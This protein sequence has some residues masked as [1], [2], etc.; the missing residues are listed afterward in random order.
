VYPDREHRRPHNLAAV[1]E[2]A[3]GVADLVEAALQDGETPLVI[4]G[5]CTIELDVLSGFLRRNVDIGLL[6]FDGGM[7]LHI[8]LDNP[9]GILDSMI[10][11][12][13]LGEPGSAEEFAR[14]GLRFPLMPAEKLA[15]FGYSRNEPEVEI[16]SRR[17]TPRYPVGRAREG[18]EKAAAE[19]VAYQEEVAGRFLGH[20]DVDVI[21]FVDMPVAAVPPAQRG[22]YVQRDTRLPRSVRLE[23]EMCGAPR[24]HRVQP[25]P[26]RQSRRDCHGLCLQR[27]S[28][29]LTRMLS[30][31]RLPAIT[32]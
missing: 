24:H 5:D 18:S 26:R 16:L 4:G 12:H 31:I 13:I 7:D 8:P 14:I 2:V 22:P 25:R 1:V 10:V 11:A 21:D 3:R 19:A 28:K 29:A 15:L 17:S 6:Y 27:R 32:F 20:F 9:T 23:L 30:W